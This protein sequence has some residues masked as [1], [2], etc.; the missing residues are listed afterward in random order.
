MLLQNLE[1]LE[2]KVKTIEYG[3]FL[4]TSVLFAYSYPLDKYNENVEEVIKILSNHKIDTFSNVNVRYEFLDLQ[5][6]VL[7][8]EC[9]SDLLENQKE[10]EDL[11]LKTRLINIRG[12]Y[13]TAKEKDKE[14]KIQ[15]QQLKMISN[16]KSFVRSIYQVKLEVPGTKPQNTLI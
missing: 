2:E 7:I 10:F 4:D 3:C 9:I 6:R 8:P 5:R 16:G 13:R 15:R 11:E 14:Y 1:Q 12:Q